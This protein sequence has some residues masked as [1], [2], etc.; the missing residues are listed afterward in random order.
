MPYI[1]PA[2]IERVKHIDLLSYLQQ[3]NP[4]KL[5]KPAQ[6]PTSP[7]AM[8]QSNSPTIAG[9]G[10]VMTSGWCQRSGEHLQ[11]RKSELFQAFQLFHTSCRLRGSLFVKHRRC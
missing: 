5:V 6:T 1:E 10:G 4:D 7:K 2:E 11:R 3:C 8:T 9:T